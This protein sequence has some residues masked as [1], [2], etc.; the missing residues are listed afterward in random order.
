MFDSLD[1][2]SAVLRTR[3]ATLDEF[4]ALGCVWNELLLKMDFPI[5][6]L[7]WEWIVTWWEHFGDGGRELV[8]LLVCED[9]DIKGILPLY[10]ER[11]LLEDQWLSGRVLT[12]C[13]AL[14]L[15]PDHLDLIARPADAGECLQAILQFLHWEYRKWDVLRVPMVASSAQIAARLQAGTMRARQFDF[16]VEP[17]SIAFF[18]HI[19]GAFEDYLGSLNGKLR[20]NLRSRAKKLYAKHDVRFVPVEREESA[21]LDRLFAL[22]RQRAASK[23]IASSLA[24]ARVYAFHQALAVR[25]RDQG[26]LSLRELRCEDAVIAASYNF[27]FVGRVFSYQ[28]GFDPAWE[29]FG[30]GSVLLS[31]LIR[32]AFANHMQEYN[33]LQGDE[34]YKGEWT[35]DYR[36]LSN[37]VIYNRSL[38]GRTARKAYRVKKWIKRALGKVDPSLSNDGYS[39]EIAGVDALGAI[40]SDWNA[41]AD[42]MRYPT[43]FTSFVWIRTWWEHFG[44]G[45]QLRVLLLRRNGKLKGVLPLFCGSQR[46]GFRG[47]MGRVLEYAGAA[48]LY[49]DPLDII[50]SPDDARACVRAAIAHLMQAYKD[51]DVAH[52][53]FLAEEGDLLRG[54]IDTLAGDCS[55]EETSGA[56]YI[57]IVGRYEDH[58]LG[59]SPN[60]RAKVR[61]S[62]RRLLDEQGVIYRD[63]GSEDLEPVLSKLFDLHERRCAEKKIQSSFARDDV[64]AFHRKLLSRIDQSRIWLRGLQRGDETIAIFYGFE[65]G[66]CVSYYQLGHDPAWKAFSPGTV[67]LQETIRECFDRGLSEYNFLQGDEQFKHRWTTHSRRLFSVDVFR[68]SLLGRASN[69]TTSAKRWF[70]SKVSSPAEH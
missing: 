24:D 20:Y 4:R 9:D 7:T 15:F 30:P 67:L 22:H 33:L 62:R 57:Q 49:P 25:I 66:G 44:A 47:R 53:Q 65:M 69:W 1:L 3:V 54:I 8:I 40:E 46:L 26:W 19:D 48:D 58:V 16:D 23:G 14:D 68:A 18:V 12:L 21:A 13:G 39:V 27:D 38:L 35:Q 32:E 60:E 2:A 61:R 52:F 41:L 51:W 28:K 34:P 36:V 59:L 5:V 45:R 50:S 56:P 29:R 70:R 37:V 43:V 31:E 17:A 11:V 42:S 63:L 10:A 6:F 64:M 55:A